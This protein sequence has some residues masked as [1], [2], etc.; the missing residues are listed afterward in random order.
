MTKSGFYTVVLDYKGGT[1]I[2][3]A[4]GPSPKSAILLW[5]T[6]LS[7]HN[8]SAW[9]ISRDDLNKIVLSDDALPLNGCKNV[10]CITGSVKNDLVLINAIA[11]EDDH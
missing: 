9:K 2:G 6:G 1:Y 3:Q 5:I 4:V 11:T 7:D 8:L 10:W